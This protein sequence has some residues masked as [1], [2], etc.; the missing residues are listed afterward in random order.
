MPHAL[1]I[2][3]AV[4]VIGAMAGYM[5]ALSSVLTRLDLYHHDMWVRFGSARVFPSSFVKQFLLF[6]FIAFGEYRSLGDS[7]LNRRGALARIA[8]LGL[9]AVIILAPIVAPHH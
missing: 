8:T 3:F 1:Q 5:V 4:I 6:R 7:E 9:I 2:F